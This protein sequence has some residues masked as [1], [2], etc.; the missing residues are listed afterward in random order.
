MTSVSGFAD[1]AA[2]GSSRNLLVGR[3]KFLRDVEQSN[4][5]STPA[6]KGDVT[7]HI[8]HRGSQLTVETTILRNSAASQH[9]STDGNTSVSTGAD[10][11]EFHTSVVWSG[12]TLVFSIEEHEDGRVILSREIWMLIDNCTALERRRERD[13]GGKQT[14]VYLRGVPNP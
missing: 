4:E 1:D 8:D 10:G 14:I 5:R 11:D 6:R 3:S 9:Y 13:G 2:S 7:L 12:Q